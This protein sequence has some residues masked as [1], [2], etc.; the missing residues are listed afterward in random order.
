[1]RLLSE[2]N[3]EL[4]VE[5]GPGALASPLVPAAHFFVAIPA[6]ATVHVE[7]IGGTATARP[8]TQE[9]RDLVARRARPDAALEPLPAGPVRPI[10]FECPSRS[11]SAESASWVWRAIS[12]KSTSVPARPSTGRRTESWFATPPGRR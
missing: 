11:C 9:E 6:G 3:G 1:V 7:R 5:V 4:E 12:V 2:R 8:L 10:P